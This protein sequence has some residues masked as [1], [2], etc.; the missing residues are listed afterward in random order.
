M[1]LF[2][3]EVRDA[4]LRYCQLL[5]VV[6]HP[7]NVNFIFIIQCNLLS[8]VIPHVNSKYCGDPW[9]T[10]SVIFYLHIWLISTHRII[11]IGTS[12][13]LCTYSYVK[14]LSTFRITYKK[15]HADWIFCTCTNIS[16]KSLHHRIDVK[17]RDSS[18]L[19]A[20]HLEWWVTTTRLPYF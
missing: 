18:Y 19:F 14:I 5:E 15:M 2:I 7:H 12:G 3:Y 4:L 17:W 20:Q 6:K 13:P 1:E 11:C 16:I 10:T 9:L 8:N